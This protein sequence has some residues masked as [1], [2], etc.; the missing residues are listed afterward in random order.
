MAGE[1]KNYPDRIMQN[2]MWGVTPG[3][4]VAHIVDLND[5]AAA[6]GATTFCSMETELTQEKL[7]NFNLYQSEQFSKKDYRTVDPADT[8]LNKGDNKTAELFLRIAHLCKDEYRPNIPDDYKDFLLSAQAY[9]TASGRENQ[10]KA[11]RE[12]T[13][14]AKKAIESSE[15]A[16]ESISKIKEISGEVMALNNGSLKKPKGYQYKKEDIKEPSNTKIGFFSFVTETDDK[17][18]P[19]E[20]CPN[21]I[22]QGV[23]V[24][25]CYVLA[26]L[27]QIASHNPQMIKDSMVDNKDGTV[28]VRFFTENENGEGKVPEYYTVNKTVNKFYGFAD[29][30]ASSSLWVQMMEKAYIAHLAKHPVDPDKKVNSYNSIDRGFSENFLNAFVPDKKFS[31]FAQVFGYGSPRNGDLYALNKDG[32]P[33]FNSPEYLD[34]ENLLFDTF[35]KSLGSGDIVTVS[36]SGKELSST[37]VD[38]EEKKKYE[39]AEKYAKDRGIRTG[40][41]YSV[42]GVFEKD[43]KKFVQLKDP[44]ATFRAKYNEKGEL[45]NDS[46]EIQATLKGGTGSMGTFNLELKD[47]CRTFDAMSMGEA[48]LSEY[49]N[50]FNSL[51]SYKGL[52]IAPEKPKKGKGGKVEEKKSEEVKPEEKKREERKPM[53]LSE[54]LKTNSGFKNVKDTINYLAD[55]LSQTSMFFSF[56]NSKEFVEMRDKLNRVRKQMNEK[57]FYSDSDIEKL[58]EDLK[59]LSAAAGRYATA[60]NESIEK[61]DKGKPSMRAVHRFADAVSL[62]RLVDDPEGAIAQP[63]HGFAE[64]LMIVKADLNT[65]K[66]NALKTKG[67]N[68]ELT[69]G[70]NNIS[71]TLDQFVKDHPEVANQIKSVEQ[72]KPDDKF[73]K[74]SKT[75]P[76]KA[77]ETVAKPEKQPEKVDQLS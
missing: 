42:L 44:Y 43:G 9:I 62:M 51:P 30:Y 66:E 63:E 75:I 46:N 4:H 21:D 58:S 48:N 55:D 73:V 6:T 27:A 59:D 34:R 25:D 61:N 65:A 3:C 10:Q 76:E 40:H 11:L 53:T 29:I 16:P 33:K 52:E 71:K 64:S 74:A 17:L 19:H 72:L 8:F 23:G 18:F 24:E 28:T 39:L 5:P 54:T 69:V 60:K 37:T 26:P 13:A 38:P 56:K 32:T 41:V 1:K 57:N 67:A 36:S 45:V 49:F 7:D 70:L 77:K 47:F 20:P 31:G 2:F 14:S 15:I 68:N 22:K 35:K 12:F 50:K